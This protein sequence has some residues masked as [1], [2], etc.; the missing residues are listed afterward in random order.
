MER[1]TIGHG[2]D[3]EDDGPDPVAEE[4]QISAASVSYDRCRMDVQSADDWVLL[5]VIHAGRGKPAGL[6]ALVSVGDYINHAIFNYE[7]LRGG[8]HRL[9]R[10]GLVR[11]TAAGWAASPA[12]V[13]AAQ[14]PGRGFQK[15]YTA[16]GALMAAA[17][18]LPSAPRLKGLTP[19]RFEAAVQAYLK[20][21]P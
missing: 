1:T 13:R 15:Q 19:K 7:E 5:T 4:L 8:L 11:Q 10:H 20:D 9:L 6:E 17:P 3:G 2:G 12:A 18:V 16:L 14:V 21:M